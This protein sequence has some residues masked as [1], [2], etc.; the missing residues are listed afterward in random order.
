[1]TETLAGN[2]LFIGQ[3]AGGPAHV[4][5]DITA[6]NALNRTGDNL[7]FAL[8]KFSNHGSFFRLANFLHNHLLGGLGGNAAVVPPAFNR[9]DNFLVK[10]GVF[11]NLTGI[12][13]QNVVLGVINNLF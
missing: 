7:S 1:M 2:L 13:E 6:L 8:A 10:L 3:E 12:L 11:F 4:H 9:K 5:K